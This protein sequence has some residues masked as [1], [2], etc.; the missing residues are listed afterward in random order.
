MATIVDLNDITTS[1]S[2]NFDG[3]R[4][5]AYLSDYAVNDV[6]TIKIMGDRIISSSFLNSSIG[7][8]IDIFGIDKFKS[9]IRITTTKSI[10]NQLKS[11]VD[12]YNDFAR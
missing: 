10:F 8:Y 11:Y 3:D 5:F 9:N 2:T 4:L 7:K 6:V 1:S 12:Y